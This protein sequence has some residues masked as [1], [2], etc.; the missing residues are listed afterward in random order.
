MLNQQQTIECFRIIVLIDS[1]FDHVA[2][3]LEKLCQSIWIDP[4]IVHVDVI[5]FGLD[6]FRF[7]RS[8]LRAIRDVIV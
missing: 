1:F 2:S 8:R 5:E 6:L 4:Q 3:F 7:V